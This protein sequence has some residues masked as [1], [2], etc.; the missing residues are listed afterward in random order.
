MR[1]YFILITFFC[2]S[3]HADRQGYYYDNDLTVPKNTEIKVLDYTKKFGGV[4]K[5]FSV[6]FDGE[7]EYYFRAEDLSVAM[8][9]KLKTVL[10]N[11]PK[12][13]G[14]KIKL[15]RDLATVISPPLAPGVITK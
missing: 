8:S 15:K 3:T 14:K 2:L 1:L 7:G 6:G 13:V 10:K 5:G 11:A 12:I 4:F 9:S